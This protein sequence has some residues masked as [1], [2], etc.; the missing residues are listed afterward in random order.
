MATTPSLLHPSLLNPCPVISGENYR[1]IRF[2]WVLIGQLAVTKLSQGRL[3]GEKLLLDSFARSVRLSK[4]LGIHAVQ[5]D[6]IDERA[7]SFYRKYGFVPLQD[8]PHRLVL[9]I[10]SI[11][12]RI[13][14][15]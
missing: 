3:L 14:A 5:V 15:S 13:P 11:T 9:P 4:D 7:T 10:S 1:A 12:S 2:L 6:A 8:Q